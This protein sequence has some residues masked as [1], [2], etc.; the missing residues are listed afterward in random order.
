ME[1]TKKTLFDLI[2]EELNHMDEQ[3]V[4]LEDP[5][6]LTQLEPVVQ[7]AVDGLAAQIDK[8]A[9]GDEALKTLMMTAIS[10]KLAAEK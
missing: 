2:K 4:N 6:A 8:A 1:I 3:K 5:D 10:A 7:K 9:G